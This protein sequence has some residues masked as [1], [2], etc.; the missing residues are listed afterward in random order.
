MPRVSF[1]G[2]LVGAQVLLQTRTQTSRGKYY[3]LG[4]SVVTPGGNFPLPAAS[5]D[6]HLPPSLA[7]DVSSP[8]AM[9]IDSAIVHYQ[10]AN[11]APIGLPAGSCSVTGNSTLNV[12]VSLTEM[13]PQRSHLWGVVFDDEQRDGQLGRHATFST[14]TTLPLLP[15]PINSSLTKMNLRT[16]TFLAEFAK[17]QMTRRATH[18]GAFSDG[19][20]ESY[21]CLGRSL[22]ECDMNTENVWEWSSR[23]LIYTARKLSGFGGAARALSPSSL[24]ARIAFQVFRTD[25]YYR[26]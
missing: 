8:A 14:T 6:P 12:I 7:E 18:E 25:P 19:E 23:E 21:Q 1:L 4:G 20:Y 13:T 22:L 16:G 10:I 2:L 26:E 9:L 5:A 15:N 17:Y 24:T 11:A 3:K